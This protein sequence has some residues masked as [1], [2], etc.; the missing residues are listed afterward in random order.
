MT[1]ATA[2][3]TSTPNGFAKAKGK[4]D[5]STVTQNCD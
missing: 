3:A 2:L 4:K 5:E 1:G